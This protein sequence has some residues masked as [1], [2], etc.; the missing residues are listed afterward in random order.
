MMFDDLD[1]ECVNTIRCLA[2]DQVNAANSGHPGAP[3][4]MAPMAYVLF[5]H[6]LHFDPKDPEWT[7]RDR[8]VLSNGHAS[9]LLYSLLHVFG[10]PLSLDQLR[11]FR[12]IHSHTP[13]HPERDLSLGIE[14]TT[15]ALG[16]GVANAVGMAIA[17]KAAAA[18]YPGVYS[19]KVVCTVGDGCLQEGVASEAC[20]LAGRLRLNNLIVLYDNNGISIDGKTDLSFIE[21]VPRRFEAYRWQ[22]IEV[23]NGDTDL[24][25]IYD[26]LD[27]AYHTRLDRPILISVKTT[28][29]YGSAKQGTASVHGS[30]L[31]AQTQDFKRFFGFDP[32]KSF[33]I[34]DAA[35][36]RFEEIIAAKQKNHVVWRSTIYDSLPK[37]TQEC[38]KAR[39][40]ELPHFSLEKVYE[41]CDD[42]L[43]KVKQGNGVKTLAT[44]QQSQQV[45]NLMAESK[46]GQYMLVGSADLMSSNLTEI[47]SFARIADGFGK[48]AQYIN[49]GVREHAMAAISNGI[50]A[51]GGFVSFDAT[52]LI[53]FNYCSPAVRMGALSGVRAVHVFTHDSF[54]LG[55]DGGTHHPIETVAWIR[56][57]PRVV[58]WRPCSIDEVYGCY[59]ATFA[60]DVK[61]DGHP[62]SEL[63]HIVCLSRQ[64]VPDVQGSSSRKVI[65]GAYTIYTTERS[66][67]ATRFIFVASGSEVPLCIEAVQRLESN[68]S[69]VSFTVVSMPSY[70]LFAA[71]S[72]EEQV[73]VI[74]SLT[75]TGIPTLCVE[76]YVDFGIKG[77]Y[78]HDVISVNDYSLSGKADDL[79]KH[80]GLTVEAAVAKAQEMLMRNAKTPAPALHW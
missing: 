57:M 39:F 37:D 65:N 12:Q 40:F 3:V 9:A 60:G 45:L 49:Y 74:P 61:L 5:K 22:V 34:S 62:M 6:F 29:G 8:F 32:E 79:A 11:Q 72:F 14:I 30:P 15:G 23:E 19:N 63:Q 51:Y 59:A 27:K 71:R 26:A 38:I 54:F 20:S 7:N 25:A 44:R 78:A 4:G 70:K 16:Q 41:W 80:F 64:G 24:S 13:G 76:P 52:F 48:D 66:A 10:Y 2:V 73:H 55:E 58:D 77:K 21:D 47:K 67:G 56:S 35:R 33:Y 1:V 50:G 31:G 69:D 43:L 68:H 53:F 28:I 18:K 75:A 17:A 42:A 36:G 46:L